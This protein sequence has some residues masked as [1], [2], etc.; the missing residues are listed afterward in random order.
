MK[1]YLLILIAFILAGF[2]ML[3]F[4]TTIYNLWIGKGIVYVSFSISLLCLIFFSTGMFASIFVFAMN[5]IGALKIQFFS[6][7]LS[8]AVFFT[9]SLVLIKHFHIG[10][11]AMLISAILSN[12]YGYI[13]APF[14]YYQIFIKRS[15]AAI[16]Y[17]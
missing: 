11:E 8:S 17:K 1:K 13:V 9:L 5:G 15:T 16:W 6:S 14:Q 12:F 2:V 3:F 10:V 7:L 4:A